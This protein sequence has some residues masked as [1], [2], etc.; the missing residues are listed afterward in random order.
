MS[1]K[2]RIRGRRKKLDD[3]NID[4]NSGRRTPERTRKKHTQRRNSK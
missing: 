4:Q 1:R 2:A 3:G